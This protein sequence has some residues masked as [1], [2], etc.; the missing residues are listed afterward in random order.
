MNTVLKIAVAALAASATLGA[1]AK[2][3]LN[4]TSGKEYRTLRAAVKRAD[5][6][7]V[8]VINESLSVDSP[9]NPGDREITIKGASDDIV[10]TYNTTTSTGGYS[11]MIIFEKEVNEGV[12][13][14]QN[15][16]FDGDGID[17]DG[18]FVLVRNGGSLNLTDVTFRNF[19]TSATNGIIRA[20]SNN[21]EEDANSS[22]S[23]TNV[24][25]ADCSATIDVFVANNNT[26]VKMAGD[27]DFTISLNNAGGVAIEASGLTN[28]KPV[29]LFAQRRRAGKAIVKGCADTARF[30]WVDAPA[31]LSLAAV[32]GNLVAEDE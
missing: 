8:L 19:K 24:K 23:L 22:I 11:S 2:P 1:F 29:K 14:I 25:F 6:G 17:Y 20:L 10:L 21:K 31:G 7:D 5:S 32:D 13:N 9:L 30:N 12:L 15:V 4:E 16:T 26:T 18:N 28:T 27:C 3:I